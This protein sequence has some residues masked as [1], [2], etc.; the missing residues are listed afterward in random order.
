MTDTDHAQDNLR[1]QPRVNPGQSKQSV[2]HGHMMY[3]NINL[4]LARKKLEERNDPNRQQS[5]P[6]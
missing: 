2:N 6:V 1:N 3:A 4:M 5:N